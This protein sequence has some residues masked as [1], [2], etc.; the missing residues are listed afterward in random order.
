MSESRSDLEV[1]LREVHARL[2]KD[3]DE[4][5]AL[6]PQWSTEEAAKWS[7]KI[8]SA[9]Q[10]LEKANAIVAAGLCS[11][12]QRAE[13]FELSSR[14]LAA[15]QENAER[16]TDSL[17]SGDWAIDRAFEEFRRRWGAPTQPESPSR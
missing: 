10:E 9:G 1:E 16:S 5:A 8:Q 6:K 2:R 17:V 13:H 12:Q 3:L 15:I 11:V 14:T 7:K 4:A